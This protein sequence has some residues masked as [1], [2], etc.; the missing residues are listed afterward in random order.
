MTKEKNTNT[1]NQKWQKWNETGKDA[2]YLYKL[3]LSSKD[4]L[5]FKDF[6]G[7]H[8]DWIKEGRYKKRNLQDN[9]RRCQQR[10]TQHLTGECK[11]LLFFFT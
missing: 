8:K 5:E 9:F 10:L 4:S 3:L 2:I 6:I 11:Y 7:A 1:K